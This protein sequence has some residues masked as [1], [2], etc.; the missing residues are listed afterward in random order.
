MVPTLKK[1]KE[2]G[3]P[4]VGLEQTTNSVLLHEYQ[5]PRKAALVIGSERDG[6][7]DDALALLDAVVEIPVWGL[8]YS[9]NA[10]TSAIIALYEYCRQFPEG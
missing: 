8:P 7:A 10:A 6:I 1:L 4:L 2:Q 3:Y 5:F 9:Y